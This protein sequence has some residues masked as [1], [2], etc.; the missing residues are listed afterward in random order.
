MSIQALQK[1]RFTCFISGPAATFVQP[2]QES[3]NWGLT[4]QPEASASSAV[5]Q[6]IA[7]E[8]HE[9]RL[10]V[11]RGRLALDVNKF[12]AA[13]ICPPFYPDVGGCG[14]DEAD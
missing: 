9:F 3:R 8:L 11:R 7:Q 13:R 5:A 1:S 4:V 2:G 10:S 14:Q 6:E 12:P